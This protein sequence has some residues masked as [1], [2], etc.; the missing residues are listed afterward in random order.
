[1]KK[2]NLTEIYKN[3]EKF[4]NLLIEAGE[5]FDQLPVDSQQEIL[6]HHNEPAIIQYCLQWGI[7]AAKELREDWHCIAVDSDMKRSKKKPNSEMLTIHISN[8]LLLD[9]LRT[10]AIEY[11]VSIE[12][13]LNLAA[14]RLIDDVDFLRNL[15]TGKIELK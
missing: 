9:S 7:L 6:S 8:P 2:E 5:L 15:R 3:T 13:L 14:K 10:L 4:A 12:L 11:S 1:M